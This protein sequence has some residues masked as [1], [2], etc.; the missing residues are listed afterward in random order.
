MAVTTSTAFPTWRAA[1]MALDG[2][3]TLLSK[4][5]ALL[6]RRARGNRLLP[7][8]NVTLTA[9]LAGSIELEAL[10]RWTDGMPP[11]DISKR[12]LIAT[13]LYE[14]LAPAMRAAAWPRWLFLER[15]FFDSSNTG[16]LLFSALAI[17]TMCEEVQKLASLDL[18][19]AEIAKL[20]E[21]DNATDNARLILFLRTAR[22]N[23]DAPRDP[24]NFDPTSERDLDHTDTSSPRLQSAKQA[25]NDYV[26]PN[27]GSHIAA[28]FPERAA[29]ARVLL[30][31][32]IAAYDSFFALSWAEEPLVDPG[33]PLDVMPLK[34]WPQTVRQ[35]TKSVLSGV[36]RETLCAI[37]LG[38]VPR[39]VQQIFGAPA[40]AAWLATDHADALK[41]LDNPEIGDLVKSLRVSAAAIR[42]KPA[43]HEGGRYH[44][45]EGASETDVLFLAM[46]SEPPRVCRRPQLLRGWGHGNEE[47]DVEQIFT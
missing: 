40:T 17:R 42:R 9:E 15:A 39:E 13:K 24:R 14:A 8:W 3:P 25:L 31:G 36:K 34:S 4:A 5:D 35:F 18:D 33:I 44:L 32:I 27:Y 6:R 37:E 2:I 12:P 47:A 10:R 26:H 21:S 19:A 16:D 1:W 43:G 28:L 45:W 29:A 23:L 41:F 22:A 46:A 11:P 20:A 7:K 30:E 38:Q